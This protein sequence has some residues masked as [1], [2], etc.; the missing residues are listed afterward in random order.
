M[1]K[2]ILATALTL[3]GAITLSG[4]AQAGITDA[5][6]PLRVKLATPNGGN[7][8]KVAKKLKV[9][10][11]CNKDCRA[12]AHIKLITPANDLKVSGSRTLPANNIWTTGMILTSY[13]KNYLKSNFR[14]CKFR[15]RISAVDVATGKRVNKVKVFKFKR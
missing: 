1:K 9:L 5:P 2:L 7:K 15:V 14:S 6:T 11:S 3:V 13:G 8:V 4:P 10:A 12:T